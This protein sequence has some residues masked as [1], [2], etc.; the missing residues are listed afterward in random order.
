MTTTRRSSRSNAAAAAAA[1]PQPETVAHESAPSEQP[2]TTS[3]ESAVDST[4]QA[5]EHL[6]VKED[7]KLEASESGLST[8]ESTTAEQP[9]EVA[10]TVA[11][12]SHENEKKESDVATLP[13]EGKEP[14]NSIHLVGHIKGVPGHV[15]DSDAVQKQLV[16]NHLKAISEDNSLTADAPAHQSTETVPQVE[17]LETTKHAK[18][19]VED[20]SNTVEEQDYSA[21][22]YKSPFRHSEKVGK[23]ERL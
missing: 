2:T 8:E 16:E 3:E 1:D 17:E 6:H 14:I 5:S 15:Q 11:T 22:T 23:E 9:S 19:P 7:Q 12:E 20:D 13:E 4:H 21:G 10:E 18:R